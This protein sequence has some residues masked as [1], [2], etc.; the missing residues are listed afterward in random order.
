MSTSDSAGYVGWN[1]RESGFVTHASLNEKEIKEGFHV[2][3]V[4]PAEALHQV[5]HFLMFRSGTSTPAG[6]TSLPLQP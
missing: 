1:L 3:L 6:A 2:H 5:I 4:S